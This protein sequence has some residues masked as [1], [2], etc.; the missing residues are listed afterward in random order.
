MTPATERLAAD[1]RAMVESQL[2]TRG[3]SDERLL[4]AMARVPRHEFVAAEYWDRAYADHPLPIGENQTISQPYMVALM[5]DKLHLQ[6]GDRVLEVGAGSGYVS[7]LL[8]ELCQQVFAV[9]RVPTLAANAADTLSRLGY[10]NVAIRQGDG[11]LGWPEH[12]P[13]N[14]RLVSAAA[15]QFPQALFAQ[16]D[17]GGRLIVPVGPAQSQQLQLIENRGGE[18]RMRCLEQCRFVPL[19]G[20]QGYAAGWKD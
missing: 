18:P 14:A 7:A 17:E 8:A 12:A 10:N 5:L 9:E 19:I 4:R 6:P 13:S 1:R 3:I 15:P 16:L 2:R 20:G 11:S